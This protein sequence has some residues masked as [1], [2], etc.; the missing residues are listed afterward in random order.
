MSGKK[1]TLTLDKYLK[2]ND[3]ELLQKGVFI[4]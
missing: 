4:L 3:I 2:E 1:N